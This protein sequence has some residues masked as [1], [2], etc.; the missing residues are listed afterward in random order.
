M[1]IIPADLPTRLQHN[2][3]INLPGSASQRRMAPEM[4][5]GRHRGPVTHGAHRAAVC[6]C[7][8]RNAEDWW[9]PLTVRSKNLVDHAGQVSLPGGRIESSE[10]AM[11]AAKR[12][13]QEEL[14]VDLESAL[15]L[16]KLSSLYV[17]GSHHHVEVFVAAMNH[18]PV[19]AADPSE[20]AEILLMPLRDL[21]VPEKQVIATMQRGTSRFD[22]PGFRCDQH[23]VW[24]ATAMI[25]AEFA[26]VL[27]RTVEATM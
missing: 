2:L 25:L 23:L 24:G 26:D 8:F 1:I 3:A 7:L 9:F 22:A 17:Y 5:F 27:Q 12:E 13:F 10:G 20:V 11:Q 14:G 18:R 19:F 6:I 16:G 21:M 4:A 15:W